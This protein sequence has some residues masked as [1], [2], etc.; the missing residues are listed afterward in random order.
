LGEQFWRRIAEAA[1]DEKKSG[2]A[3]TFPDFGALR[4]KKI[5]GLPTNRQSIFRTI[6]E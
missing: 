2:K 1:R 3:L 6:S 5:V 4:R